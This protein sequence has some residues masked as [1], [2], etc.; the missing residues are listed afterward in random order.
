[1]SSLIANKVKTNKCLVSNAL[2]YALF[3]CATGSNLYNVYGNKIA[4]TI[5]FSAGNLFVSN[6]TCSL[7]LYSRDL[8]TK[9][10]TFT[11]NASS[12]KTNWIITTRFLLC[13]AFIKTKAKSHKTNWII[14]TRFLLCIAF[15][16][17]KAKSLT[18]ILVVECSCS[19]I[20]AKF[21]AT[22][23]LFV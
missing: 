17:T 12:H 21:I 3:I 1:M 11:R 7:N 19:R 20:L 23:L 2:L 18:N 16:K 6:N 9:T 10:V 8:I 13:L 22:T 4:C 15:I 14:T 5:F